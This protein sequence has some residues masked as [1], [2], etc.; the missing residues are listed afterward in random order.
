MDAE[1]NVNPA[2]QMPHHATHKGGISGLNGRRNR[3]DE[4]NLVGR[5]G[6]RSELEAQHERREFLL[7]RHS[8]LSHS[9]AFLVGVLFP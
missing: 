1:E 6:A 3:D 8:V 7:G 9:D 2:P 5:V 4:L